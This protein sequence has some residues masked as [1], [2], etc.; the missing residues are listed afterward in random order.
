MLR[1][2]VDPWLLPKRKSGETDLNVCGSDLLCEGDVSGVKE[3]NS[4]VFPFVNP[5]SSDSSL[6]G[7]GALP[8]ITSLISMSGLDLPRGKLELERFR[9]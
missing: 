3:A 9:F 1:L 4:N 8:P 5:L 6:A 7:K 2:E